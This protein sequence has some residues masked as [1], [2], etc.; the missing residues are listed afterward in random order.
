[1]TVRPSMSQKPAP[2]CRSTPRI[3]FPGMSDALSRCSNSQ[4]ATNPP[5][6]PCEFTPKL[7]LS[8]M[9]L[10]DTYRHTPRPPPQG[11]SPVGS[12]SPHTE[13]GRTVHSHRV[14][15]ARASAPSHLHS[16]QIPR[17]TP[18]R[19]EGRQGPAIS[20]PQ[21]SMPSA[22]LHL[23]YPIAPFPSRPRLGAPHVP[24]HATPSA[25]MPVV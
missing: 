25:P 24:A 19:H 17:S 5:V 18:H 21:H 3:F 12:Q 1:M 10:T 13:V 2:A 9:G 23:R 4:T 6:G 16:R 14:V 7:A 15:S 20:N 8:Y 11:C 22:P